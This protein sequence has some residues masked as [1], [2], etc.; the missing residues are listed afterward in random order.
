MSTETLSLFEYATRGQKLH[1]QTPLLSSDYLLVGK[2]PVAS[3]LKDASK[4]SIVIVSLR[5][6]QGVLLS[7]VSLNELEIMPTLTSVEFEGNAYHA[8]GAPSLVSSDAAQGP[9]TNVSSSEQPTS[10]E[11][12]TKMPDSSPTCDFPLD[13]ASASTEVNIPT[14]PH[15]SSPADAVTKMCDMSFPSNVSL[16]VASASTKV[17]MP[18][19][20]HSTP[21][22]AAADAT[23]VNNH[24]MTATADPTSQMND[25]TT[26][27]SL[28]SGKKPMFTIPRPGVDGVTG[29][30]DGKR[31]CLAGIFPEVGGGAGLLLG[32][33]RTKCMIQAFGGRVTSG[34]SGRTDF[35]LV[36]QEP[37]R[38]LVSAADTRGVPLIDLLSL[39][40]LLTG[41]SSMEEMAN[42]PPPR[43]TSFGVHPYQKSVAN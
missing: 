28:H 42:A 25:V 20:P 37:G 16:D 21:L 23:S 19:K 32:T 6:L 39:Q 14:K 29:V 11:A 35:L 1:W 15:P 22:D 34:V 18:S 9:S 26:D 4:R 10:K 36:G 8:A 17:N 43:I 24:E 13:A 12:E 2:D 27:V 31:F 41:Q 33:E 40:R 30:L 38:S 5:R 7:Q 3:K